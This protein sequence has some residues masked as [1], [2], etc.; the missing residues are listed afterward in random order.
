MSLLAS[1]L[2]VG[3]GLPVE[4]DRVRAFCLFA[5]GTVKGAGLVAWVEGG[6]LDGLGRVVVPL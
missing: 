5:V 4:R 2:H 1:L 6:Y 3:E